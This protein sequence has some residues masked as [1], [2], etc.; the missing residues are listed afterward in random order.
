MKD[1]ARWIGAGAVGLVLFA[2]PFARY[3]LGGH[4]EL[5]GPHLD[6]G[7]RHGGHLM[8]LRGYH[9]ELVEHADSIELYLSDETRKPL[10][11][12][13]CQVTFDGHRAAPCEW[14][15]YR[16]VVEKPP[17]AKF[18]LYELTTEDEATLAFRFP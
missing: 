10:R 1:A 16:S 2:M 6:H 15:G 18:G 8:M 4:H 3:A 7:P 12:A 14:K 17:R 11:P 13:S 9:A 5:S